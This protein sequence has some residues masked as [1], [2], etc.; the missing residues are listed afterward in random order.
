MVF[1]GNC[2]IYRSALVFKVS[3]VFWQCVSNN[4]IGILNCHSRSCCLLL[5]YRTL[6]KL[7]LIRKSFNLFQCVDTVGSASGRASGLS[8]EVLAWLSV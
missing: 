2:N 8:D 7:L 6:I 3:E 4:T 5:Y 1:I